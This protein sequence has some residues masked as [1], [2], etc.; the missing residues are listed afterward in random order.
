[1]RSV[2][3]HRHL[4]QWVDL[5]LS[6]QFTH[7]KYHLVIPSTKLRSAFGVA[8]EA[9]GHEKDYEGYFVNMYPVLPRKQSVSDQW[10]TSR[11][12]LQRP[13]SFYAVMNDH[14][15]NYFTVCASL[16]GEL[17]VD[18]EYVR[19]QAALNQQYT[20]STKRNA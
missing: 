20:R 9:S 2:L 17:P 19:L 15:T 18:A 7:D 13:A 10:L 1:M 12:G 6:N 11:F 16:I 14:G 3:Q 5:M 8:L 4:L